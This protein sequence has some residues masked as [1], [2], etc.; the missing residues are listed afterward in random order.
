VPQSELWMG[1]DSSFPLDPILCLIGAGRWTLLE[2]P[3]EVRQS[4]F[5]QFLCRIIQGL[6]RQ[7]VIRLGLG[8]TV[9]FRFGERPGDSE[10]LMVLGY[11]SRG[12]EVVVYVGEFLAE[13]P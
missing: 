6:W 13:I 4:F 1:V 12:R 3:L 7:Y 5:G 11:E 8:I 9:H 2:E 10:K